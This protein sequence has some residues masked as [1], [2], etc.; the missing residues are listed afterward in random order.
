MGNLDQN[1][2]PAPGRVQPFWYG[3]LHHSL[4]HCLGPGLGSTL[5][6]LFIFLGQIA[7]GCSGGRVFWV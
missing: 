5:S 7:L 2:E 6:L 4:F 1:G 3:S